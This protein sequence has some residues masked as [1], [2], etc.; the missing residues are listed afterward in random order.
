MASYNQ[1]IAYLYSIDTHGHPLTA[2]KTIIVVLVFL[3]ILIN[4]CHCYRQFQS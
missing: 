4:Y 1:I 2:I 3:T